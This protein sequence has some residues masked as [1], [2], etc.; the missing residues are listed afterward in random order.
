MVGWM[1]G[2]MVVRPSPG[3]RG[4]PGTTEVVSSLKG[5]SGLRRLPLPMGSG[6]A[7]FYN[8]SHPTFPTPTHMYMPVGTHTHSLPPHTH[9]HVCMCTH[10]QYSP[11]HTHARTHIHM[12]CKNCFIVFTSFDLHNSP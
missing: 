8:S 6:R 12:H 9:M 3:P 2:G 10:T 1:D 4:L 7:E 5:W 11:L